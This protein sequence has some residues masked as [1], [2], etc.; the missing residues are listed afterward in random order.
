MNIRELMTRAVVTCRP[1]DSLERAAQLMEAHEIGSAVVVGDRGELLG[2]ITDR[3]IA[4]TAYLF[5]SALADIRVSAAMAPVVRTC[6]PDDS[7][8]AAAAVMRRERV[9]RLPVVEDGRVVGVVSL[10]DLGRN[11]LREGAPE[12][13]REAMQAVEHALASVGQPRRTPGRL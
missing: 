5:G 8:Q 4:L 13:R 10:S 11:V 1:D 6:T 12:A 7:F 2:M 3:D 9:R